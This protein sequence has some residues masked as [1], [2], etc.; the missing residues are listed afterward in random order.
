MI[1]PA[2]LLDILS[3]LYEAEQASIFRF[4]LP[5]NTYLTRATVEVRTDVEAM[6]ERTERHAAELAQLI[7][8]LG[9][10]ARPQS[11]GSENQY[12]A[13]LSLKFLIPK[14]ANA[15][16]DAV[17]RYENAL[18]AMK[19]G[20]PPDVQALLESHL[21]EDRAD[22]ATLQRAAALTR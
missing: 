3:G 16:R 12:L 11:Q 20:A 7:E 8:D 17:L 13:Y 15:Q 1:T 19:G 22:L 14:L 18:K 6:G 5:G 9:G 4:M 21:A 2:A 10:S